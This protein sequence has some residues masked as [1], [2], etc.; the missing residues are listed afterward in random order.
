MTI[1]EFDQALRQHGEYRSAADGRWRICGLPG[2][3]TACFYGH[4][5]AHVALSTAAIL[6]RRS[7]AQV[8]RRASFGMLR[9]AERAGV[10]VHVEGARNLASEAGGTVLVGNH[11]STYET[12][13]L[14]L[15]V[16]AFT[17]A[18]FVLKKDLLRYPL[19][20]R[21]VRSLRPIAVTRTDPRADL[22]AVMLGG[23]AALQAGRSVI[24]FPQ[25]TRATTFDPAS[26]NSIGVKLAQRAGAPV[27]PVAVKTDMWQNGRILKDFGRIVPENDVHIAFGEPFRITNTREDHQRVVDFIT[28]RLQQWQRA[29]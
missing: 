3:A 22:R 6:L 13:V 14:P 23:V 15:L 19:F 28:C 8:V 2:G 12:T 17:D 25:T 29:A 20:G 1:D 10:V 21:I 24:V 9:A 11:M 7:P 4:F 27:L 18:A 26:F 5:L 16:G